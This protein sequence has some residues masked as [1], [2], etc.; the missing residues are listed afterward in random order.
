[1]STPNPCSRRLSVSELSDLIGRS[2]IRT[3]AMRYVRNV[4]TRYFGHLGHFGHSRRLLSGEGVKG[5]PLMRTVAASLGGFAARAL[6]FAA[7]VGAVPCVAFQAGLWLALQ[8]SV[9]LGGENNADL[10]YLRGFLAPL[11]RF[12][13]PAIGHPSR[14]TIPEL[15]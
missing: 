3:S 4:R 15:G 11:Y 5:S 10:R 1:M 12:I 13:G 6:R 8:L 2:D 9:Q 14:R 7:R